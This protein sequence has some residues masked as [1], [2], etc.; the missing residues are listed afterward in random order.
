[1]TKLHREYIDGNSELGE[2]DVVDV[3]LMCGCLI[4]DTRTVNDAT[5]SWYY[6]DTESELDVLTEEQA[7]ALRRDF[8]HRPGCAATMEGSQR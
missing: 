5:V 8:V 2:V 7:D 4:D 1:M 3:E 6:R